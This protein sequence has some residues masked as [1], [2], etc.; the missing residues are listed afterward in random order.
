MGF[1]IPNIVEHGRLPPLRPRLELRSAWVRSRTR[2]RSNSASAP[3]RSKVSLPDDVTGDDLPPSPVTWLK[4]LAA[5]CYRFGL[6]W[7]VAP[8]VIFWRN[9]SSI[10][11][12]ISM[13]FACELI[14]QL[15][16]LRS[17]EPWGR[18]AP[19]PEGRYTRR[20]VI[21]SL[22]LILRSLT[23]AQRPDG[24]L[25]ADYIGTPSR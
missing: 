12:S 20:D 21:S 10:A 16:S 25:A 6:A 14:N 7:R 17:P 19:R 8:S 5:P 11:L 2:L 18:K 23:I 4:L 3:K 15:R 24:H 9:T 13:L 1:E 22:K